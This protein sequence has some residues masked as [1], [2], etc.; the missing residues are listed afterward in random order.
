MHAKQ[1]TRLPSKGF[2]PDKLGITTTTTLRDEYILKRA[3]INKLAS[4]IT[5]ESLSLV[6]TEDNQVESNQ[7][8]KQPQHQILHC[9]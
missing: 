7:A 4:T 1:A 8:N 9:H 3:S 6:R 2:L 5:R